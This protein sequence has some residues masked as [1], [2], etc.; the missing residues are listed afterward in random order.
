MSVSVCFL[1]CRQIIQPPAVTF[2]QAV[3]EKMCIRCLVVDYILAIRTPYCHL[4][5]DSL[6]NFEKLRQALS[7]MFL[8]YITAPLFFMHIPTNNMN[9]GGYERTN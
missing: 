9:F 6:H 2:G 4:K 7:K 8:I 5:K 3:P 1:Y